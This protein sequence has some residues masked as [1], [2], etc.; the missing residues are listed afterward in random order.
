MS[1]PVVFQYPVTTALFPAAPAAGVVDLPPELAALPVGTVLP[2]VVFPP[3]ESGLSTVAV[4]L[5][6]GAEISFA[7]GF[8]R[9]V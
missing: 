9:E 6:D 2:A 7:E 5:P 8:R 3:D 1:S 4:V